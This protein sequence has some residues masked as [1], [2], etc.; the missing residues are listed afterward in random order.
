MFDSGDV[1][2]CS[3]CKASGRV[4]GL[5]SEM[6]CD[7]CDGAGYTDPCGHWLDAH[8]LKQVIEWQKNRRKEDFLRRERRLPA[9]L[10]LRGFKTW[11][12]V[13]QKKRGVT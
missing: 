2:P 1:K 6:E 10:Q 8:L 4:R 11:E 5:F 3:N 12:E 7:H 9:A 13:E